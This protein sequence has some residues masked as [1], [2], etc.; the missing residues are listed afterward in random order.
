MKSL[1]ALRSLVLVA[2]VSV[3]ALA[4]LPTPAAAAGGGL[5]TALSDAVEC[6]LAIMS[7]L[8]WS[9]GCLYS[10]AAYDCNNEMTSYY[11]MQH[12]CNGMY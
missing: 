7:W 10:K 3:A 8:K 11:Y 9:E 1:K 4:F 6:E 2:T 12:V 5:G